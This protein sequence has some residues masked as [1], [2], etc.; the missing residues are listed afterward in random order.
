MFPAGMTFC[1]DRVCGD[2]VGW[3][4]PEAPRAVPAVKQQTTPEKVAAPLGHA[5][6][7]VDSGAGDDVGLVMRV[8]GHH[9]RI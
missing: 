7:N 1:T 8:P 5:A 9:R 4:Q 3:L 6:G 2:P